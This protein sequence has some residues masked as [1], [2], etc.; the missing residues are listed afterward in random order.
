MTPSD[1]RYERYEPGPLLADYIEHFWIVSATVGETERREILIPNGRPTIIVNLGDIGSRLDPITGERIPND[2]SVA[3]ISTRPVV[4]AQTGR[5]K[6]VAAQPTPFG[7]HALG[8]PPLI[9]TLLSFTQWSGAERTQALES[10]VAAA[11][12]GEPSARVLEDFLAQRLNPIPQ[13]G[14]ERLRMAIKEIESDPDVLGDLAARMGIGY[15]RLYRQ[16]RDVVGISPKA[17]SAILRYQRLVGEILAA[18]P[19]DGLA[20]LALMQGYYDQAHANR[21]FRR[22]TGVTPTTFQRTLNGIAKMMHSA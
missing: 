12:F 19:G 14:L 9:D 10:D 22:F 13:R 17:F 18:R 16:F 3:G 2:T 20:Q 15:D 6:L 7:L 21:D 11:D 1:F 8:C 5:S 4:I